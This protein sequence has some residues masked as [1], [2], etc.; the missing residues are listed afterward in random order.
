VV[1]FKDPGY[2]NGYV[3]RGDEFEEDIESMKKYSSQ[4]NNG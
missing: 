2:V 4:N 1:A 3:L